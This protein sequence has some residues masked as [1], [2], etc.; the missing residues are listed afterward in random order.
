MNETSILI[1]AIVF[2]AFGVCNLFLLIRSIMRSGIL[3]L[4]VPCRSDPE[5]IDLYEPL[6]M[7]EDGNVILRTP[8]DRLKLMAQFT[9]IREIYTKV[10]GATFHND[11]GTDRQAILAACNQWDEISLEPYTYKGDPAYAVWTVHGRIGNLPADV[12]SLI[13]NVYGDYVT[14]AEIKEITGGSNGRYYGCNLKLTVFSN[15]AA[16]TE[17]EDLPQSASET[18]QIVLDPAVAHYPA[19]RKQ[20]DPPVDDQFIAKALWYSAHGG[21]DL[22]EDE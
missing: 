11:D 13:C 14:L 19:P 8:A 22:E 12:A 2:L 9:S 21:E 6:E 16:T 15:N 1:A 20:E 5:P 18:A 7:D 3:A 17:P 10:S 4:I